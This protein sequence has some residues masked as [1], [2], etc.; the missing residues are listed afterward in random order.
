[1][2]RD[3]RIP[4]PDASVDVIWVCLVL[5]GVTLDK[6]P[7][8]CSELI[9]VLRSSGLLFLVE[10]IS[11]K[12]SGAHWHFRSM[13]QYQSLFPTIALRHLHNYP[14]VGEKISIMAGRAGLVP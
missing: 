4:L 1:M 8:V 10:N 6:L 14:D 13:Q 5:G 3:C 12:E 7:I 2:A 9:R 11:E